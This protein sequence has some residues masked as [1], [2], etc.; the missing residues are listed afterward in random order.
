[1][2]WRTI[3][4]VVNRTSG[5]WHPVQS[6]SPVNAA[7]TRELLGHDRTGP[8]GVKDGKACIFFH[9]STD[10]I[11]LTSP[12]ST[13][14]W[15]LPLLLLLLLLLMSAPPELNSLRPPPPGLQAG[16]FAVMSTNDERLADSG[17]SSNPTLADDK[18]YKVERT[19]VDGLMRRWWKRHV[20][21]A[22]VGLY[23]ELYNE[24]VTQGGC[25]HESCT[26]WLA[27]EKLDRTRCISTRNAFEAQRWLT[28]Y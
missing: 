2:R 7:E 25:A 20:M 4:H 26:Y 22:S 8:R 24:I 16:G 14:E 23:R 5:K 10:C 27:D 18:L 1:M 12:V 11:V 28:A 21:Q 13:C 17:P 15:H 3:F 19:R 6:W 9:F